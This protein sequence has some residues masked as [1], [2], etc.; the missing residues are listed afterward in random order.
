M[1]K[2]C[3]LYRILAWAWTTVMTTSPQARNE[4]SI[5]RAMY[6][7]IGTDTARHG[8]LIKK[9]MYSELSEQLARPSDAPGIGNPDH[10]ARDVMTRARV[11]ISHGGKGSLSAAGLIR[12]RLGTPVATSGCIFSIRSVSSLTATLSFFDFSESR[13]LKLISLV[14]EARGVTSTGIVDLRQSRT[15]CINT[16]AGKVLDGGGGVTTSIYIGSL[17][18]QEMSELWREPKRVRP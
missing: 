17:I 18:S 3:N 5:S 1:H 8:S 11:V 9:T 4:N 13:F 2:T 7:V 15:Y 16:G 14:A 10:I 12:Y 6:L